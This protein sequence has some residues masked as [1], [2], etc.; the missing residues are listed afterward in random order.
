MVS[1]EWNV[2]I[3]SALAVYLICILFWANLFLL[4]WTINPYHATTPSLA[5]ENMIDLYGCEE[6][7]PIYQIILIGYFQAVYDSLLVGTGLGFAERLPITWEAAIVAFLEVLLLTFLGNHFILGSMAMSAFSKANEVAIQAATESYE[8]AVG[9]AN[10]VADLVP[11]PTSQE[12]TSRAAAQGKG[13]I[14]SVAR[15]G[16]REVEHLV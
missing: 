10:N 12:P 9:N 3:I 6:P 14:N 7:G 1:G 13:L 11:T 5:Q 4:C 8:A 16:I 2:S 15:G